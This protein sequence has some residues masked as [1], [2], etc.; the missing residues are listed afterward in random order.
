MNEA[1]LK[2]YE[3][4]LNAKQ[5]ELNK[6][7]AGLAKRELD[8]SNS[9][10]K[11]FEEKF[12]SIVEPLELREKEITEKEEQLAIKRAELIKDFENRFAKRES[13]L[14]AKEVSITEKTLAAQN[15]ISNL[16]VK[17]LKD[18]E[19]NCAAIN[20][21]N[22][23]ELTA[24]MEKVREANKS[25]EAVL[26]SQIAQITKEKDQAILN[27]KTAKE[28]I[29]SKEAYIK[30]I[31]SEIAELKGKI[32]ELENIN[33]PLKSEIAALKTANEKL[34]ELIKE[35][36]DELKK[37]ETLKAS[38]GEKSVEY[39]LNKITEL[40]KEEENLKIKNEEFIRNQKRFE[41]DKKIYETR[42]KSLNDKEDKIEDQIKIACAYR[43][44]SVEA[45]LK[46]AEEEAGRLRQQIRERDRIINTY[47]DFK[48][49]QEKA[50]LNNKIEELQSILA[51]KEEILAK[52]PTEYMDM[53][54]GKLE[55]SKRQFELQK[56][57]F[58][59]KEQDY[60]SLQSQNGDLI[61]KLHEAEIAKKTAERERALIQD[62]Y[63]RLTA[64]NA[65]ESNEQER[66]K[67][68]NTPLIIG[69]NLLP[70]MEE[71]PESEKKWLDDICKGIDN[72]GLHFP[73]RIINAFHT[74]LKTSEMSPLTVLAGVSGTGKSELPR[75][76]SHF[77]GIN[78]L[79]IPVQPNW[80]CQESMLGYFNSI[81]NYFDAQ[82]VLR[83]LAQSQRYP[84]DNLGL[85]DTMTLILLDEMNL[86][87]VELYFSDFLSKLETRR[88]C[89]DD[90]VPTLGVKIGAKMPDWQLKLG[91]NVL[92]TGTMNQDE[93]TKTLSDKVLDRG[94]VINFPRP[95]TFVRRSGKI[96]QLGRPS[97]LLPKDTWNKWL[98]KAS[99][100]PFTDKEIEEYK[101]TIQDIND[102]LGATGRALG[103]RVWQSIE[104]YMANYP[105]VVYAE[106]SETK[107][108]AMDCAF[109][110]QIVQKVM[111]KLRGIETRG[112]QGK[113]LGGI[114][115]LI[116]ATLHPDFDNA[117]NQ[118]YGQFMW[119]SSNYILN[120]DEQEN[121]ETRTEVNE[122]KKIEESVIAEHT[123]ETSL[124]EESG[125]DSDFNSVFT[126]I[127]AHKNAFKND[128]NKIAEYIMRQKPDM[129]KQ[130]AINLAEN[131]INRLYGNNK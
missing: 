78:F 70:K 60:I 39:Y 62:A 122:E 123:T 126:Y 111:P 15:E 31:T 68:I 10:Q 100:T 130:N 74:S 59:K 44:Q 11:L 34:N 43:I 109:E 49:L 110:D 5:A 46:T 58:D 73:R 107:K 128:E 106:D 4:E 20:E 63:D 35:K 80:D 56:R 72:F 33:E 54:I 47:G 2:K 113:V 19:S 52:H 76:Y 124:V 18:V 117:K 13:E 29:A 22:L 61:Q 99:E 8:A 89:D 65:N 90:H 9:Y 91:R 120:D 64:T 101:K 38:L 75:L 17:M 119:C 121:T 57:E 84:N 12:K 98:L 41:L 94:I 32:D 21:K 51:H 95:K 28:V 67:A 69:E 92:W 103:H 112:E 86:A 118:G 102:L 129:K 125:V 37:L 79:G 26:D 127:E 40:G 131:V 30:A 77:G 27:E 88:G 96:N 55:E 105:D 1:E 48:E 114:R 24:E 85:N 36:D 115:N 116:P 45:Q 104:S 93:T 6:K 23:K 7:E 16:K 97:D 108:K 66:I 82:D 87:N 81:D 71:E 42:N 3:Q 50:V 14:T 53:E 83:L 25:R